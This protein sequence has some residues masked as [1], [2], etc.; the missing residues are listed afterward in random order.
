YVTWVRAYPA[1]QFPGDPG[2]TDGT[3]IMFALSTDGGQTW[4]TRT[5]SDPTTG[6]T[7][8]AIRDPLYGTN[9]QGA[10]GKGFSFYPQVSIGPEGD[11]YVSAYEGGF[12]SVFF[13]SDN[14]ASFRNPNYSAALGLPFPNLVLPAGTSAADAFRSLP[15]R[16]IVADPSHPGRVYV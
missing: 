13:S 15:V 12:F 6:A 4:T 3:D 7:V 2:S 5:Q 11:I 10:A 8:S 1:G 14:G 9:D 16:D